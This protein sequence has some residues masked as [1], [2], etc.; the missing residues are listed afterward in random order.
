MEFKIRNA[1]TALIVA[2]T[3]IFLLQMVL[4]D[5]FTNSFLLKSSDIYSR[6][7][8]LVTHMFLHGSPYHLLFN[9]WGLFMFGPLLEARIG[10]RRF[11][12]FYLATGIIAGFLSSFFYTNA[13]G[14]SGAIMGLV[15]VIVMLMP[16]LPIL[17]FYV[18]PA[19]LWVGGIFFALMDVFGVFFPTGIGSIAHLA[20]MGLGL[21]YGLMLKKEKKKFYS[22]F[23]SKKHLE[24]DDLDEYLKSGRI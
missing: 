3:L 12:S 23:T 24:K 17:L 2:D 7:W 22:K 15:G 18:V 9:M 16:E 6:P 14:A 11:I 19:P 21:L 20:G 4:G 5:G 10:T 8:I 13:L 1:V